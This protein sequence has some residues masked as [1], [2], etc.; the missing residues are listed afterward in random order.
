MALGGVLAVVAVYLVQ[1]FGLRVEG[2]Q[3]VVMSGHVGRDAVDV[4]Q[5]TEVLRT[6]PVERGAVQLGGA[7]HEVVD[8]GLERFAVGVVP[9]V[10]RRCN[11]RR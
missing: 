3:V 7:A 1:P 9:R 6:Q 4:L 11:A 8:L 10:T 5:L 2:F